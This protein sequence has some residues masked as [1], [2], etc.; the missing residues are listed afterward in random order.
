MK[1]KKDQYAKRKA[2]NLNQDQIA[3]ELIKQLD[4][5]SIENAKR[6]LARAFFLLD[7]TQLVS[8]DRL[9]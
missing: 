2:I 6:A 4:G 1:R 3:A 7:S 8:A 5:I 9:P